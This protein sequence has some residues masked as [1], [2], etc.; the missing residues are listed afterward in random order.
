VA[1]MHGDDRQILATIG[2]ALAIVV[3][4]IIVIVAVW[5][6]SQDQSLRRDVSRKA[7]VE[8]C[9]CPAVDGWGSVVEGAT[10]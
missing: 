1:W 4:V 2:T 6:W 7:V 10:P 8:Q 9:V 3:A 5:S